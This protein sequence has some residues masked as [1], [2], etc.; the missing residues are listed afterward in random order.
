MIDNG[1]WNDAPAFP[2]W[3]PYAVVEVT[4]PSTWGD[5]DCDG[6][7]DGDD[8]AVLRTCITGP[9]GDGR[10]GVDPC[11][12]RLDFDQDGDVD[13]RDV[14]AFSMAFTGSGEW[15]MGNGEWGMANSRS[16]TD[17]SERRMANSEW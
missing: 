15:R 16:D 6:D 13:L 2:I 4:S 12:A 14:G 1:R 11:P 8:Y 3:R 5:A 10:S 17:D 9:T 7:V